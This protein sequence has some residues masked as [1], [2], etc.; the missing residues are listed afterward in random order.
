M[1]PE[2]SIKRVALATA[3]VPGRVFAFRPGSAGWMK[4]PP[5]RGCL[6]AWLVTTLTGAD[7]TAQCHGPMPPVPGLVPDGPAWHDD[8]LQLAL[9]CG[10]E[11]HYRG[12]DDVDERWEWNPAVIGFRG[13]LEQRWLASLRGFAGHGAVPSAA[14]PDMLT[15]LARRTGGPDLS[16]YLAREADRVQFTEYVAH[17]SVY[18]L[19]EADPHSFGIPRLD[20]PAK[21]ALVEI[22]ADEYGGGLPGR[23]HSELFRS[24]MRWA[25]LEDGYGH[26]VPAVPAV[27]LAVSN[28][29]SLFALNRRWLGALL[30]HLAALEMTSTGPNRRYSGGARA[31]SRL[32]GM[33][34]RAGTSTSMSRLM[35]STS[36]S[37]PMTCAAASPCSARA[38][39]LTSCSARRAVW[40]LMTSLPATCCPAGAPDGLRWFCPPPRGCQRRDRQRGTR[41]ARE[42]RRRTAYWL[43]ARTGTA[44]PFACRPGPA[45]RP[46]R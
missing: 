39:P 10:Y 1:T 18:Q 38:L 7:P 2:V 30:G 26:Y 29:M 8:D 19:K 16:G 43:T 24:T 28:L 3:G 31:A 44:R 12:F 15:G 9:W 42:T 23:M 5:S 45:A 25:G 27:T 34:P 35:P 32:L 36:R 46:G 14:V 20:G 4:L 13:T 6:S 33:R 11:L 17:R 22:Q 37:P 40:D 41:S 21:A